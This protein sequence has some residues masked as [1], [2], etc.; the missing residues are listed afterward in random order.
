MVELDGLPQPAQE[1]IEQLGSADIVIGVTSCETAASIAAAVGAVRRAVQTLRPGGRTVLVHKDGVPVDIGGGLPE[2]GE[3]RELSVLSCPMPG[4]EPFARGT[5]DPGE[6]CSTLFRIARALEARACGILTSDAESITSQVVHSIVEPVLAQSID[7][8]VACYARRKFEGLINS[9]IAYP[10]TRAL[11]GKRIEC[12]ISPDLGFSRNFID[13]SLIEA[14]TVRTS[15]TL[16]IP[17]SAVVRGFQVGEVHLGPRPPAAPRDAADLSTVVSEVVGTLYGAMEQNAAFWQRT[18]GSQPVRTFGQ[19]DVVAED[20]GEV[21]VSKM[22]EAFHLGYR[23]LLDVWG[24]FLP[25]AALVELKRLTRVPAE[26]FRVGDD[27]WARIV[28]DFGLGYRLRTISRDHL[29]R[30]MTPLY[31][32]WV[33]AYALEVGNAQAGAVQARIERLCM[34]YE[35]QKPYLLS[36][37]RWPDR[38][39]P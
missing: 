39:N 22:I 6:P 5:L 11:Y 25:P 16:W 3:A 28:Y 12:P 31:L 8:V 1:Q 26:H 27:L 18:R 2:Q 15:G 20:T 33:A 19:P 34:A 7:L 36:R 9:G 4:S 24:L 37:W 17:T 13:K 14:A 21:D 38:F 30:A 23:N 32:G 10:L 29:L 35:S